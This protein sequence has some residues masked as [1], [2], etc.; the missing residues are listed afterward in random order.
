[1]VLH[2]RSLADKVRDDLAMGIV[3]AQLT[4]VLFLSRVIRVITLITLLSFF[5]D[6]D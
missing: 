1:M 3:N 4:A 5:D 6:H 2:L